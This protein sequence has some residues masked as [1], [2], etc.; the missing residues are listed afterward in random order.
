MPIP[1]TDPEKQAQEFARPTPDMSLAR[2]RRIRGAGGTPGG[3]GTFFIGL[4]LAVC[5][6]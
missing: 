6:G 5:G 2:T 1:T 4:V 3:I